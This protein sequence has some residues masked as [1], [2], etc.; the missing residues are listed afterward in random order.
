MVNTHGLESKI[1]EMVT[2]L[3]IQSVEEKE[4]GGLAPASRAPIFSSV[5]GVSDIAGRPSLGWDG[6]LPFKDQCLNTLLIWLFRW[7]RGRVAII[8]KKVLEMGLHTGNKRS[9]DYVFPKEI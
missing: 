9:C 6:A 8:Q 4:Y 7:P 2:A 1:T 3:Q 5:Y